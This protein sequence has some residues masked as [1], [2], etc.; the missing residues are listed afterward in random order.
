MNI[1]KMRSLIS[2][3]NKTNLNMLASFLVKKN[4]QIIS[5]S[6]T[7]NYLKIN[8][9]PVT[10]VSQITQFPEIL[11]GRVKT[12]HPNIFGPL[13]YDKKL[14]TGEHPIVPINILVSNL[15]PFEQVITSSSHTLKE[16]VENID[17]GGHSL[18]R[19]AA[20]NYKNVLTI[21]NPNDY[22]Y[23]IN[24]WDNIDEEFRFKMA[25]K[26]FN[27]VTEYDKHISNY[28]NYNY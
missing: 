2:V 11:G 1:L 18:I 14:D 5:T 16:A 23:V 7:F 10:Q 28:F 20:K 12:L 3:S 13:L 9:H 19:A 27:H 15:Y 22:D 4:I 8:K 26:A 17:I 21:V 24:N 6:G 25:K